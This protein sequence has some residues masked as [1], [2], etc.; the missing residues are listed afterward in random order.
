MEA[1]EVTASA[2]G[3]HARPIVERMRELVAAGSG[4]GDAC[5]KVGVFGVV[6]FDIA[7]PIGSASVQPMVVEMM[8]I[9]N[10]SINGLIT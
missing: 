9:W 10:V 5:Q 2:V 4:F 8:A 7:K 3:G 6:S 1:L